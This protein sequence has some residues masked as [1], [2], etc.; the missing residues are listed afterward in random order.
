MAVTVL[1]V[2]PSTLQ[3]PMS[4]T[5]VRYVHRHRVD[6]FSEWCMREKALHRKTMQGLRLS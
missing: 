5:K 1:P 3:A 2:N 4:L 6:G